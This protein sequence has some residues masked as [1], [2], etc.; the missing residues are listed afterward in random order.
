MADNAKRQEF[1][2]DTYLIDEVTSLGD[3]AFRLRREP[4]LRARLQESPAIGVS[5]S[6]GRL[7]P[8]LHL[9]RGARGGQAPARR[10]CRESDRD[11]QLQDVRARSGMRTRHADIADRRGIV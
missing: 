4:I 2:L 7:V 6:E 8:D 10:R 9:G 5:H 3:A 1:L 11:A